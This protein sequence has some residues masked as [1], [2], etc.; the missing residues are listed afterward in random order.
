M[1]IHQHVNPLENKYLIVPPI[2]NWN[3]VYKDPNQPLLLDLG[4]AGGHFLIKMA[5]TYPNQN[6]LGIEIRKP[7]VD[8]ANK[9]RS[10]MGL[11]NLYFFFG[12]AQVVLK[13][14]LES[15]PKKVLQY[16]TINFPD[17][18][19]K[20]RHRKRRMVNTELL[21]TLAEF[22][23]PGGKVFVQTDVEELMLDIKSHF[24]TVPEFE[25]TQDGM[26]SNPF[27]IPT[28]REISVQKLRRIVYRALFTKKLPPQTQ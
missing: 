4:S 11:S 26:D 14:I 5:Q 3:E 27:H 23:Q 24:E 13:P 12:Q 8:R 9:W 16:V 6:F 21:K 20:K 7:L 19:F 17:P 1:R 22:L 15:F 25:L 10:E 28:E 2:P 18:W